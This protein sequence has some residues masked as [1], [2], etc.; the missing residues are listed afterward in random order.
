MNQRKGE[1]ISYASKFQS[2]MKNE[3]SYLED[4]KVDR[5]NKLVYL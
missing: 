4:E 2:E 1:H 5:A 3:F